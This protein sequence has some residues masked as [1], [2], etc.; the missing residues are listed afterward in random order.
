MP[1]FNLPLVATLAGKMK[2]TTL[3]SGHCLLAFAI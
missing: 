2:I 3:V 1:L